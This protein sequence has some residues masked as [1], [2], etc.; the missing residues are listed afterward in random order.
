MKNILVFA[1]PGAAGVLDDAP[2]S[3][4]VLAFVAFCLA[5]SGIYF[6]NDALDVD[7]DRLH[8]TKRFRPIAAGIVPVRTAK[9]VGTV[10][11]VASLGAAAATGR[12]Q[13]VAVVA[14]YIVLTMLYSAWLK[15]VAVIDIVTVA[16]GFVLRAAA[17]AAAVDVPMSNW[18][19]L[20]TVFGSLFIVVG[21]R[22]AEL[23]EI[24]EDAAAVRATL[25]D[26]TIGYLRIV[27]IVSCGAA[28]SATASGHSRSATRPEPDWPFYELSI[29]PMLTALLRYALVLEQGAARRPRRS[30][31]AI[32]CCSC[33]VLPGSWCSDWRCTSNDR[34]DVDAVLAL[35]AGIDG[36]MSDDQGRRLYDAAARCRPAVASSRS[37]A[38]GA[39][40]PSCSP[41]RRPPTSRSSPSTRTP[42][43]TADHRR[44][45]A[46]PTRRRRTARSSRP[47]SPRAG[48]ADR[49][50][51]VA[52]FSAAAHGAVDDPIDVLYIDGAHRYAPARA[53]IRDWGARVADGGTLLIHDSFS[54]VGVTLA[55]GRELFAGS[56]VPL[57]RPFAVADRV[58]RRPAPRGRGANV[59][60]QVRQLPWFARNVGLKVLLTLGLAAGCVRRLGRPVP[61][62][63]Y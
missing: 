29:V 25:A 43:T 11:L 21:K 33:S 41:R 42:A 28:L 54:S 8:P 13:T 45:R 23:R 27:L 57:R 53:D 4:T 61:E 34:P 59:A 36:W 9:V 55:I 15:H 44:S 26:Y 12:W 18:F 63:P 38:S 2:T 56:P 31:P 35:T 39:A 1:A 30:S 10:L 19:V 47:T 20:V 46:S 22:Y 62:W 3:A 49:V 52:S 58:P 40:R 32:A 24:G 50:R 37:A 51:H 14:I 16:S 48:V 7:A 6:W 5:A 60:R 17:G